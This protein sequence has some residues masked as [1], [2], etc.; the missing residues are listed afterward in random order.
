MARRIQGQ[1]GLEIGSRI[2][3]QHGA[4]SCQPLVT[5]GSSARAGSVGRSTGEPVCWRP[6]LAGTNP[7]QAQS[8]NRLH[9]CSMPI[10]TGPFF[11]GRTTS[12]SAA[13][14]CE[15]TSL[16]KN[17]PAFGFYLRPAFWGQG[18]AT[19]A[20][21]A[22]IDYAFESLGIKAVFAGRHPQNFG[23][24][25]ALEKLGFRYTHDQLYPPTGLM[26]P[27]YLVERPEQAGAA[28]QLSQRRVLRVLFRI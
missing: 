11:C 28:S 17:L 5:G 8:G 25:R 19:E 21:R 12:S 20:G 9:G 15:P 14:G 3:P 27:C 1:P 18:F 7:G 10:N 23:S 2:F 4:A 13:A 26:H 24:H 16:R 22:A 6:F